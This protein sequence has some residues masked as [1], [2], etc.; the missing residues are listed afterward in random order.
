MTDISRHSYIMNCY[1]FMLA[2]GM[3]SILKVLNFELFKLLGL[4][5]FLFVFL[6]VGFGLSKRVRDTLNDL[7][8]SHV[9][10]MA[11]LIFVLPFINLFLFIQC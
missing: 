6:L 2:N 3:C 1:Y 9:K 7:D 10:F 11:L 8:K 4:I 5:S